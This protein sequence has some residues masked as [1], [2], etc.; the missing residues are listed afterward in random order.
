MNREL[1]TLNERWREKAELFRQHGHEATARTYEVCSAEL[2]AALRGTEEELLD[3]Q[4]AARE[5]GY[6]PDHLGRL[7][8]D[9]KIPNFGRRNAPKIKR[10]DLPRRPEVVA[11]HAREHDGGMVM[12]GNSR[13]SSAAFERI[14]REAMVSTTRRE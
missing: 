7:V 5:P 13:S 11:R 1:T 10:N 12:N 6:R 8:H 14:A 9:G 2:E 3:L 4:E